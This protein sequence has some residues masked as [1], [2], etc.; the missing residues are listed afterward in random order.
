[1]TQYRDVEDCEGNGDDNDKLINDGN[2]PLIRLRLLAYSGV[3]TLFIRFVSLF[4]SA[5]GP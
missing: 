3:T 1:V 4:L 5:V 2:V